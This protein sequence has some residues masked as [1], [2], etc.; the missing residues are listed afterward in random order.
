MFRHKQLSI[1]LTPNLTI[2]F[3]ATNRFRNTTSKKLDKTSAESACKELGE[4]WGLPSDVTS[5]DHQALSD[6]M[7]KRGWSRMWLSLHKE[8]LPE[9]TWIN[10]D[11]KNATG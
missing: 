1:I 5:D 9:W 10:N 3:T 6:E 2:T 4:N 8:V 11:T 7:V